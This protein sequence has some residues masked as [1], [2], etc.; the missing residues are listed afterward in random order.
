MKI[1]QNIIFTDD[2][3][4]LLSRVLP[5]NPCTKCDARIRGYC[6]GCQQGTDYNKVVKPYKDN[7]VYE[8]ALQ[9][10]EYYDLQKAI[11]NFIDK[12][13]DILD[14]LPKEVRVKIF[15]KK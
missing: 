15:K 2:D 10:K 8:I 11:N 3:F 7:N 1:E 9:I 13:D 12:Q 4:K 6:C 5:N 14:S